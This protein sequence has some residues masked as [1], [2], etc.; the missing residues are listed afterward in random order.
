M[1][2]NFTIE[3]WIKTRATQAQGIVVKNDVDSTWEAGEKA[4]YLTADGRAKYVGNGNDY[5]YSNTP[6]NDGQW[7]HVAVAMGDGTGVQIYMD[8]VNDTASS[9]YFPR[10]KSVD[11]HCF[12]GRR[13]SPTAR[14]PTRKP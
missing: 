4:F 7:R 9:T 6:V 10:N 11:I 8:G 5:I 2:R 1:N 14:K 13:L 12:T 3:A